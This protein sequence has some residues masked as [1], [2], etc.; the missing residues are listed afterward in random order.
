MDKKSSRLP[1]ENAVGA[2]W[3]ILANRTPGRC[4]PERP[5]SAKLAAAYP[6]A[7]KAG[8]ITVPN[9]FTCFSII[10]ENPTQLQA[11]PA[12]DFCRPPRV[13]HASQGIL[14]VFSSEKCYDTL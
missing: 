14:L 1:A 11:L 10:L 6:T 5:E 7:G 4:I 12:P 13:Y 9:S 2:N 8:K 3:R